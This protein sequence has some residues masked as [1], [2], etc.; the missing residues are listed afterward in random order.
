MIQALAKR[1]AFP[2][3]DILEERADFQLGHPPIFPPVIFTGRQ[4]ETRESWEK[5]LTLRSAYTVSDN[6][7]CVFRTLSNPSD[8]PSPA[9]DVIK[10]LRLVFRHPPADWR[11]IFAHGG[12]T[13][14]AYPPKAFTTMESIYNDST[15]SIWSHPGGRSSN[16]FLP[17]LISM[18]NGEANS[19]GLF[20]G[21]EWS[22]EWYIRWE[23]GDPGTSVLNLGIPVDQLVIDPGET[24]ELPAVHIG[25]FSD[26]GGPDGATNALRRYLYQAVCPLYEGESP[27]PRVSYDHWFGLGNRISFDSL[28]A[29]ADRAADM[30]IEVF[31]VDAGWFPSG[32]ENGVGNWN[33]VDEEKFPEGLE[34]LADYVRGLGMDFGLWFEPERAMEGSQALIDHPDWFFPVGQKKGRQAFHLDLTIREAQD[35]LIELVG[36]WIKRLDLRWSRWDYNIDPRAFWDKRDPTGKAQLCY[37]QGLYRVWD[38]LMREHPRWMLEQCSSGG[39]RIDLGTMRRA[40]VYWIS[41][42]TRNPWMCRY[43]QARANR[44]LPGHLLG[45]SVAVEQ[46]GDRATIDDASILSRMLGKLAFD[47]DV[48]GLTEQETSLAKSWIEEFRSLRPLFVQ[49][50]YQLFPLP[51]CADD[52]DAVQFVSYKGDKSVVF[53]F[54]GS[55]GGR[56]TFLLCGLRSD[57]AY[58]IENRLSGGRTGASGQQLM[59]E[60]V[61]VEMNAGEAG[62]WKIE[63][64]IDEPAQSV[65]D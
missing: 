6:G 13:E 19:P 42:H 2:L 48:A 8:S 36:G 46:S 49:D 12:T 21:M 39:R 45:S 62:L 7:I 16:S 32:F 35:Y 43:M 34:P 65:E 29:Q 4:E 9:I 51:T 37:Y 30:G 60:G 63:I 64:V 10:P 56:R 58:G 54:A 17:L 31:V 38:V 26:P 14:S 52:W 57:A 24:L 5:G 61:T 20:C 47:G 1:F 40:H 44:F 22:G 41:D 25:F 33:R 53:L 55:S 15:F 59:T 27:L 3:N 18:K 28:R 50:F 11:H 23:A